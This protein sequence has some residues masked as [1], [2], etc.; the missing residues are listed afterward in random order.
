[1]S[2]L[3]PSVDGLDDDA[4]LAVYADADTDRAT[5]EHAFRVLVARFQHRVFAVCQRTLRDHLDAEEATQEVF[6]RLARHAGSFRGDAKLS[7]WLYAVARNVSTDRVRH[8]ARR[9]ATPVADVVDVAGGRAA[10]EDEIGASDLGVDLSRALGQLDELSRSLLLLVAVEGLSYAE[11]AEASGLAVGTVK[12]R[13]SRARVRLGELL[14]ETDDARART[15]ASTTTARAD[16]PD[17]DPA[18]PTR[19][20]PGP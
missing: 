2:R 12:S 13:V 4:V 20:P 10:A 8:D 18:T 5:R 1:M 9:P 14:A 6:V 3:P 19:G 7:T 11:A 16:G 15:G 17:P